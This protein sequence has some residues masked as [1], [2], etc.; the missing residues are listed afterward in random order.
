M[1]FELTDKDILLPNEKERIA[2][3]RNLKKKFPNRRNDFTK[4][5]INGIFNVSI[6]Q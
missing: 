2:I 3:T 5:E 6:K 4:E 1:E